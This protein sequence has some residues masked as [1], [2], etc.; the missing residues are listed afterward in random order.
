MIE[1]NA[2]AANVVKTNCVN[3]MRQYRPMGKKPYGPGSPFWQRLVKAW[4][5]QGLPTSQNGIA[6]KLDMSQGSVRRWFTGD[7]YPEIPQ[8][9]EIARRGKCSIHW[10]L[11]DEGQESLNYDPDTATLLRHWAV[12][13]PEARISLLRAAR[14][15]HAVQFTGD[16]EARSAFQKLLGD[17]STANRIHDKDKDRG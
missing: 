6:N 3:A 17:I 4:G 12:L 14:L 10:L 15:E 2:Q 8:L 13:T 11:T 7:G 16:P 1:I 5:R 9:I